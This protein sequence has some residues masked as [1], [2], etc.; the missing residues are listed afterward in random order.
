MWFT[1]FGYV[2]ETQVYVFYVVELNFVVESLVGKKKII[3]CFVLEWEMQ[4]D[5]FILES[6]IEMT[7]WVEEIQLMLMEI[8]KSKPSWVWCT[9]EHIK[10]HQE[11]HKHESF[12][13]TLSLLLDFTYNPKHELKLDLWE[14]KK[15]RKE[16]LHA[17][18]E[19]KMAHVKPYKKM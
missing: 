9:I 19:K 8:I 18:K 16:K 17:K 2:I 1:S 10:Q 15:F 7:T 6:W 13:L 4:G 5:L 14:L 11:H 3:N 12:C